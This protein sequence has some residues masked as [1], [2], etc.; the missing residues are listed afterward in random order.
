MGSIYWETTLNRALSSPEKGHKQL[1]S[2]VGK[3]EYKYKRVEEVGIMD[4]RL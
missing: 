4:V 3:A 1:F 2:L